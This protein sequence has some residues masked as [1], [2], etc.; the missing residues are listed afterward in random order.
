[1][2]LTSSLINDS[3]SSLINDNSRV[4]QKLIKYFNCRI[5]STSFVLPSAGVFP[6]IFILQPV[7]KYLKLTQVFM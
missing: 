3:F 2:R 1:M 5:I 4:L 6:V 7:T